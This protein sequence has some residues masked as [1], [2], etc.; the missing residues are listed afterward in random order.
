MYNKSEIMKRA[1]EIFRKEKESYM[2]FGVLIQRAGIP[3]SEALTLAW[4]EAKDAVWAIEAAAEATKKAQKY[5]KA[6]ELKAG[7]VV[8][9]DYGGE[10]FLVTCTVVS[11]DTEIKRNNYWGVNAVANNTE[12]K[13]F[14]HNTDMIRR[15]AA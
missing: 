15:S 3:F 5:I 14:S 9:I 13:F 4:Q 8:E 2:Q 7:D 12:F 1:W 10:G 11:I 6:S